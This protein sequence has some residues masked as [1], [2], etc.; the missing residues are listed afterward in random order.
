M[1]D[2]PKVRTVC[3]RAHCFFEDWCKK[4][5]WYANKHGLQAEKWVLVDGTPTIEWVQ[6]NPPRFRITCKYYEPIKGGQNGT[7]SHSD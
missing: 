7:E 5:A 2:R 1:A 6:Q 4:S 3:E